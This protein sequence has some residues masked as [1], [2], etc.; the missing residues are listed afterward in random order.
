MTEQDLIDAGFYEIPMPCV[1][2]ADHAYQKQVTDGDG[3][4]FFVQCYQYIYPERVG[5][6]YECHMTID[7]YQ[8]FSMTTSGKYTPDQAE[9][10]FSVTWESLRCQHYERTNDE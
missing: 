3:T 4:R 6:E 2:H 10:L 5:F 1:K 8:R 9:S 7:D